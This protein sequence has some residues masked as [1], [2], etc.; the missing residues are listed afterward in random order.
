MRVR[1]LRLVGVLLTIFVTQALAAPTTSQVALVAKLYRDFSFEA[2]LAEPRLENSDFVE[3]PR[4]VLLQ[5]LEPKLADLILRDR[6]CVAATHEICRLDFAPL[7][8]N[9]DP[10]GAEVRV[11]PGA[12]A[13]TVVV[14]IRYGSTTTQ[15]LYYLS[16]TAKGWR[17]RNISYESGRFTLIDILETKQ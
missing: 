9:Q 15:L 2:I 17:I 13:N 12:T 7:W 1:P 16:R 11:A 3:Q 6:A 5:Y 10:A 8:G 4:S 14:S